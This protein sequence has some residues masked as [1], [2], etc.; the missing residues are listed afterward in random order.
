VPPFVYR[1]SAGLVGRGHEVHV[2]APHDSSAAKL[3]LMD[4]LH[5]HRFQY[6]PSRL[7]S[8]AYGGGI[9]EN[10]RRHPTR[11][12]LVPTFMLA[13]LVALVRLVRRE[14]IDVVHAHWVIPQGLVAA[15]ARPLIN[16][17]VVTSAH[18]G[19]VFAMT[20]GIRRRMLRF[21]ARGAD[22]CTANSSATQAVLMR[23]TDVQATIIPMGVDLSVFGSI[24]ARLEP[25][26]LAQRGARLLFVGRLVEKKGVPYL[27][28]AMGHL[29]TL[30]PMTKLLLVGD[31]PERSAVEALVSELGLDANVEFAGA[32]PNDQLPTY[33]ASADI[34]VAPSVVSTEGDTEGLGV[35]ILE[36]AASGLPIVASDIGGITD[37][38]QHEQTGLLV[39]PGDPQAIA[40]AVNR[41]INDDV[42]RQTQARSARELVTRRYSWDVVVDR[43]DALFRSLP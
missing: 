27:I 9:L 6:A 25:G 7:E 42:L 40:L 34:F 16:R 8:L 41:L 23:A 18:G 32:V 28:H 26:H 5:V 11:W 37:I 29:R 21:A 30:S 24:P 35:V 3:E 39:E 20:K 31:G 14:R 38:V 2:L 15:L 22:S 4:G 13:E 36:A 19:D 1:L 43:F 12:S 17:P 10:L 33:Y